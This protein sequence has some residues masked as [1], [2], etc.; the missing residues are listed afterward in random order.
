VEYDE[1]GKEGV[2]VDIEGEPPLHV[3]VPTARLDEE[4]IAQIPQA[5]GD[6]HSNGDKVNKHDVDKELDEAP[7]VD[8]QAHGEASRSDNEPSSKKNKKGWIITS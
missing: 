4:S 2:E 5:C 8:T 1:N 3:L 6:D 7:E